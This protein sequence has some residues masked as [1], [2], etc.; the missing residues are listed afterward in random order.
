M[1]DDIRPLRALASK[2]DLVSKTIHLFEPPT[3]YLAAYQQPTGSR[4][5][6]DAMY[7]GTNRKYGAM[8][9]YYVDPSSEENS[10]QENNKSEEE[11]EKE[12]KKQCKKGFSYTY[13]L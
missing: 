13:N 2:P 8:I 12:S 5:G 4:F 6:A 10:D 11:K 3:A 9:T 1:L 7:H